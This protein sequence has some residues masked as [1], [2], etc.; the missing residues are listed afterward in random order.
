[1]K[2]FHWR[3]EGEQTR[4]GLNVYRPN[5]RSSIGFVLDLDRLYV[6]LRYSKVIH[7]WFFSWQRREPRVWRMLKAN[8]ERNY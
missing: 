8:N 4:P 2:W 3:K 5:D 1:M 7:K 6:R